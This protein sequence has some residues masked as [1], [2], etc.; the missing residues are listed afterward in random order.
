MTGRATRR[1]VLGYIM[2]LWGVLVSRLDRHAIPAIKGITT[3]LPRNDHV[4]T[5]PNSAVDEVM[6]VLREQTEPLPPF[7]PVAIHP[8]TD[9]VADHS[10]RRIDDENPRWHW[11]I[12][13]FEIEGAADLYARYKFRPDLSPIGGETIKE[14]RERVNG[15]YHPTHE[16][17]VSRE[18]NLYHAQLPEDIAGVIPV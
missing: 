9:D 16:L 18:S 3:T 14:H 2:A 6:V 7:A 13:V 4:T 12:Y 1:A 5:I 11:E 8:E 17:I 10:F 15:A